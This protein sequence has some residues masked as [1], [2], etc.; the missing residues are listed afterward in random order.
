MA[1]VCFL[2]WMNTKSRIYVA[3]SRFSTA[4]TIRSERRNTTAITIIKSY[5][6]ETTS[7]SLSSNSIEMAT[8]EI[9]CCSSFSIYLASVGR[10]SEVATNWCSILPFL[11]HS[12]A[13]NISPVSLRWKFSLPHMWESFCLVTFLQ[14]ENANKINNRK[15]WESNLQTLR[16]ENEANVLN[17]WK[18]CLIWKFLLDVR[19]ISFSP[20]LAFTFPFAKKHVLQPPSFII[21]K[22]L[23]STSLTGKLL[24]LLSNDEDFTS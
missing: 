20:P 5:I 17:G 13:T 14:V 19:F 10:R 8:R 4:I 3:C 12:T 11:C 2:S 6:C 15:C 1:G 18:W 23:S 7:E 16:V 9:L 22:R 21:W 24:F